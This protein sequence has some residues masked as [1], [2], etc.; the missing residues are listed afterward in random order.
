MILWYKLLQ[1]ALENLLAKPVGLR[2]RAVEDK[3]ADIVLS[4]V[5]LRVELIIVILAEILLKKWTSF[6]N[7]LLLGKFIVYIDLQLMAE[8]LVSWCYLVIDSHISAA[9]RHNNLLLLLDIP[10]V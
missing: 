6:K 2:V 5:S 3:R 10:Q 4:L 9:Q 7:F 1:T 8:T